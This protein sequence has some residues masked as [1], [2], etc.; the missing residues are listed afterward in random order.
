MHICPS[1]RQYSPFS[2]ISYIDNYLPDHQK[3]RL[4][5]WLSGKE[6]ASN[7][8]ATGDMGVIP[9]LGRLPGEGNGN[10]LQYS[11]LENPMDRGA[12][13]AIV[14]GGSQRVEHD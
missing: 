4:P 5:Q 13:Q 2:L 7:T 3:E 14:R 6:S 11:S 10:P 1:I 9:V 12:W 8:E